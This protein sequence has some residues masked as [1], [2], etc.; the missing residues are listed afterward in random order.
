MNVSD[1]PNSPVFH[2]SNYTIIYN[3]DINISI[4]SSYTKIEI[5]L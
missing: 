4:L 2:K 3:S 1:Y 5:D